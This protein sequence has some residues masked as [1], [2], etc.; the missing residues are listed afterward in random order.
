MGKATPAIRNV[1]A[2]AVVTPLARPV[3]NAFGVIDAVPLVLIDVET[4]VS[5]GVG[6]AVGAPPATSARAGW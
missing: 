2:R 3:K 1:K 5:V 4:R 6:R